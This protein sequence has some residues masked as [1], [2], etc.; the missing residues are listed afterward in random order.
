MDELKQA[1]AT[2]RK[3]SH[4]EFGETA[5]NYTQLANWLEELANRR[6]D[7]ARKLEV[8]EANYYAYFKQQDRIERMKEFLYGIKSCAVDQHY[9]FYDEIEELCNDNFWE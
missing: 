3:L 2:I 9:L 8:S 5:Q 7:E 1:I 6:E 4:E